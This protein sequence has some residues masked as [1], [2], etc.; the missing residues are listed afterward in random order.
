MPKLKT[1]KS[2]AKRF[3]LTKTGQFKRGRAFRRH[4]L[5]HKTPKQKRQLRR[6]LLV[7]SGDYARIRRMLPYS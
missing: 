3:K 2:A 5:T 1:N 7:S 6:A 4:L